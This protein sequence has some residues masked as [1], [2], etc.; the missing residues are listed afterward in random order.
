MVFD[1]TIYRQSLVAVGFLSRNMSD[2]HVELFRRAAGLL[3]GKVKLREELHVPTRQLDHWMLFVRQAADV[4]Q[5][6]GT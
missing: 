6:V 5:H 3:G 2:L 4:L 1:A